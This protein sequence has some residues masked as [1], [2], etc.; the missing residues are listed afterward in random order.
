MNA[1]LRQGAALRWRPGRPRVRFACSALTLLLA[2]GGATASARAD[3]YTVDPGTA[4][5]ADASPGA[6][7]CDDGSGSCPLRAAVMEANAHPGADRISIPAGAVTLT[8][9]GTPGDDDE[10]A[11]GDL[12]LAEEVEIS[13]A[14][15][16]ATTVEQTAADRVFY[17]DQAVGP[18]TLAKLTI[19]G[20][21]VTDE[22]GGGILADGVS[23]LILRQVAVSGNRA[24]SATAS[25]WG[26]GLAA[27][28]SS[29]VVIEDSTF[30]AN[31]VEKTGEAGSPNGG[32]IAF[33]GMALTV[34]RSVIG[35]GNQVLDE[36]NGALGAGGGIFTLGAE[37]LIEETTIAG[38]EAPRGGGIFRST[39][40]EPLILRRSTVSGNSAVASSGGGIVAF[41]SL[42]MVG[43]TLSGNESAA[44]GG[45]IRVSGGT[46]A[47]RGSTLAGNVA[48]GPA[49]GI[50]RT[51]GTVSV[52]A[53]I[54]ANGDNCGLFSTV[55]S[56]GGNVEA[57]GDPSCGLGA[58]D[59]AGVDPQLGPLADNGGLTATRAI[60]PTSPA[61]DFVTAGCPAPAPGDTD[62]RG[63][64]RPDAGACD[65]GAFEYRDLDD[66]GVEEGSDNC[67]AL[68]NPDQGDADADG[69]G[70]A[71]EPAAPPPGPG[72]EGPP[73]LSPS[74]LA[75]SASPGAVPTPAGTAFAARRARV[76]NGRALLRLRCRGGGHCHGLVRLVH[77]R[78]A[79]RGQ[80]I[81]VGRA[82]FAIPA[83][84][85]RLLRVKLSRRGRALLRRAGRR[86]L[87]LRL[88][89]RGVGRRVVV[90]IPGGRRGA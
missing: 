73:P 40:P 35:P 89:G 52:E 26:G 79:R 56:L 38:N 14:G 34:R 90:L 4:D 39:G 11:S 50:S 77:R 75:V 68:A 1:H 33:G 69:A 10:T 67:P 6:G 9:P 29:T 60:A 85:A 41:G 28:F 48:A 17:V 25:L 19:G 61:R 86:G 64:A 21:E 45:A 58:A 72:D 37:N 80:R 59:Q 8:I 30:S 47:I 13:G 32:A 88:S 70:D 42:D 43:S 74:L 24:S 57:D 27:A 87:R 51:V 49:D 63:L 66:D 31:T 84:E 36:A 12:D 7:G 54:L 83:G 20:G 23:N 16:G 53:S 78:R 76:K 46:V 81:R 65:A 44:D 15:A 82:A 18:V 3:T 62:Q 22:S 5:A 2:L 55:K 71:C